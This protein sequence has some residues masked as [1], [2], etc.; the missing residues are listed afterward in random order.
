MNKS[1]VLRKATE[2]IYNLRNT[3][4]RLKQENTILRTALHKLGLSADK[5]IAEHGSLPTGMSIDCINSLLP[6]I[7]VIRRR[8]MSHVFGVFLGAE[9][10][11]RAEPLTPPSSDGDSQPESP[12]SMNGSEDDGQTSYARGGGMVDSSRVF[13][14]VFMFAVVAFNPFRLVN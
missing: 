5:V 12:A 8:L 4:Q 6:V 14:C 2:H 3:N 1:A 7:A 13:M 11:R 10:T 9:P